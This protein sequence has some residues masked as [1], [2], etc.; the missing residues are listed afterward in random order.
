MD[1]EKRIMKLKTFLFISTKM[2]MT[3]AMLSAAE[4]PEEEQVVAR[5]NGVTIKN[6][7]LTPLVNKR[8]AVYRKLGAKTGLELI[9]RRFQNEELD[10]LIKQELIF[11][12]ALALKPTDLEERTNKRF[13]AKQIGEGKSA[14][15][16][17]ANERVLK[18][19]IRREILIDEYLA[20]SGILALQVPEQESRKYYDNNRQSFTEPSSARLH[21]I[22]LKFSKSP[23]T[24]QEALEKG[25]KILKELAEGKDFAE[26]AKQHS[27]CSSKKKGGDLGFIKQGYMPS[28]FD[29]AVISLKPGQTS[30][31][32]KTSHGFHI[33]RVDEKSP[34]KI[35][36][37]EELK[38]FIGRY[39]LKEYREK[40]ILELV[41]NL[42]Q[43]AKIEKLIK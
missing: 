34:E 29:A 33:I 26:L 22:L 42:K 11:Q 41:N 2:L 15:S 14:D 5:I 37:F 12:A 18:E 27:D 43:S 20:R 19:K 38:D 31:L 9:R 30:G 24:E 4:I 28:E 40:K 23:S 6:A 36:D 35:K 7:E 16:A 8:L 1:Y 32:V 17:K 3:A 13:S 25:N 21:H 39:L 10:N